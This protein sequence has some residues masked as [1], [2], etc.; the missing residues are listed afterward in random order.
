MT[1]QK[2]ALITGQLSEAQRQEVLNKIP[3]GNH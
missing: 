2:V 3:V 1:E